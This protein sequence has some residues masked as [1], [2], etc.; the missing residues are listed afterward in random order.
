[1]STTLLFGPQPISGLITRSLQAIKADVD[2][3]SPTQLADPG[4]VNTLKLK[5]ELRPLSLHIADA[6]DEVTEGKAGKTI[7]NLRIPF[8]GPITLFQVQPTQFLLSHQLG[9]VTG[10]SPVA[11]VDGYV[12]VTFEALGAD[13]ENYKRWRAEEVNR[14]EQW[15]GFVN[16]DVTQ[17]YGAMCQAIEQAIA[18]RTARLLELEN[19]KK[20]IA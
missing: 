14:L 20:G 4:F 9:V 17:Y 12:T 16:Q 7:V 5:H 2:A 6:T 3:A 10:A 8:S 13:P 11:S 19:F 1:M 15:V 18:S